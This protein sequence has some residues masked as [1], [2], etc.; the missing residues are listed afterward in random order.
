MSGRV[1]TYN[2]PSGIPGNISR[3]AGQAS[4]EAQVIDT[5]DYPTEY[6]VAVTID[7]TTH[8]LRKIKAGDTIASV[9]GIYVRPYPIQTSVNDAMGTS[10]PATSG[11]GNLLKRGYISAKLRG[12]TAAAKQG[13][14]YV[15]L[16][17][18][19]ADHPLGGFEAASDVGAV[20]AAAGGNTGNGTIGTVSATSS[21]KSGVYNITMTGA[22]T[23][24]MTDPDGIDFID[25]ATGAQYT[26]DG[27]SFKI[28]VG[29]TPMVAGD[30]FTVTVSVNTAPLP[31][32][33]FTGPADADGVTEIAYKI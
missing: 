31:N 8:A 22:T 28:T 10:T 29:A 16:A 6:G 17:G 14:V 15:R 12:A 33:Y 30:A 18:A 32:A 25:G 5:T 11:I 3:A 9:A 1:F 2:M 24:N 26:K 20:G 13:T 7:A 27:V 19:D 21:A 4:I 23:F